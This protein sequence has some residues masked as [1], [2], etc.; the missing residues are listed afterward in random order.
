MY[1]VRFFSITSQKESIRHAGN[2]AH[3][4]LAAASAVTSPVVAR[5]DNPFR[6]IFNS[7]LSKVS[8]ST[9]QSGPQW[10]LPS[11]SNALGPTG[12]HVQP[13]PT[14]NTDASR[15]RRIASN[16]AGSLAAAADL[17]AAQCT[18]TTVR[19]C[20]QGNY[21]VSRELRQNPITPHPF[22]VQCFGNRR[23]P[24]A[25]PP[26]STSHPHAFPYG[27]P[28]SS[29]PPPLLR[30]RSPLLPRITHGQLNRLTA[31]H[32]ALTTS[33]YAGTSAQTQSHRE[34]AV[35]TE[36]AFISSATNA[37]TR[38]NTEL[39]AS[40]TSTDY[41]ASGASH[42]Q[43]A[44][45]ASSTF[46]LPAGPRS[47]PRLRAKIIDSNDDPVYQQLPSY[48]TPPVDPAPPILADE[49]GKNTSMTAVK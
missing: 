25:I 28:F 32:Q 2:G 31:I 17:A 37:P 22:G 35:Q 21:Q 38:R 8:M 42:I 24:I 7:F 27:D 14:F 16:Q 13:S 49:D 18:A 23:N 46:S 48:P 20:K 19:L 39:G 15:Q 29:H 34:A 6:L 26:T 36:T 45:R 41:D 12:Q 9:A 11:R 3:P 44:S 30:V 4:S 10:I 40:P 5:S 43:I 1:D 47:L 33:R